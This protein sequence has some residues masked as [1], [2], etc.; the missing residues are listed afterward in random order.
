MAN[1][2]YYR[3]S[4]KKAIYKWRETHREEFREY[5]NKKGLEHYYANRERVLEDAKSRYATK[6]YYDADRVWKSFRKMEGVF[7]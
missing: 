6:I 2:P 5:A 3:E 7:I 4:V 1:L